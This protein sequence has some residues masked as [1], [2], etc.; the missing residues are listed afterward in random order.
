MKKGLFFL[1]AFMSMNVSAE[2]WVV[3]NIKG[4][5]AY[6]ENSY[7]FKDSRLLEGDIHLTIAEGNISIK[8]NGTLY[9]EGMKFIP[10][11][12]NAIIGTDRSFGDTMIDSW[13]I[14]KEN[15]V[16]FSRINLSKD[17]PEMNSTTALVGDVI[18]KC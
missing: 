7:Q 12:K 11:S 5:A 6:N 17:T 13:A 18:G 1:L 8:Q 16:L 9:G 2:C 15:K 3:N 10:V 4:Q 14:T